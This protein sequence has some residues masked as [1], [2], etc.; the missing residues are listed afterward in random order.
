MKDILFY[1]YGNTDITLKGS[2]V[3]DFCNNSPVYIVVDGEVRILECVV[4]KKNIYLI[5]GKK[6]TIDEFEN[7]VR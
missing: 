4:S 3:K 1:Q 6:V 5:A 2:D 7:V